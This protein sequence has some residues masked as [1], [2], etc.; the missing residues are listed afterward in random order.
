MV[1]RDVFEDGLEKSRYAGESS[2]NCLEEE[3]ERV[4]DR[5][6]PQCVG[7]CHNMTFRRLMIRYLI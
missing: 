4:T 3:R 5:L 7:R 6:G 1:H 2:N